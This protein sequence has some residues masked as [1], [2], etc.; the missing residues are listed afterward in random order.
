MIHKAEPR[1]ASPIYQRGVE[2]GLVK[3]RCKCGRYIVEVEKHGVDGFGP[4]A[5]FWRHLPK[6]NR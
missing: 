6:E 4:D 2:L 5:F 1:V 3:P